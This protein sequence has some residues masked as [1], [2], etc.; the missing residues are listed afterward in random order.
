M[1]Q[2]HWVWLMAVA[3]CATLWP[4]AAVQA[5]STYR[6]NVQ[7]RQV[8]SDRPC[9]S[10][11]PNA[12]KTY[13]PTERETIAP[14]RSTQYG[15]VSRAP[16]HLQY[17]SPECAQMNDAIR[18]ASTR[19]VGHAVQRDLHTEYQRKCAD[20]DNEARRQV[21]Q[22]KSAQREARRDERTARA[23][24]KAQTQRER[25]Q[26]NE[27]LRILHAKRQRAATLTAGEQGDLQRFEENYNARCKL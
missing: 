27:M 22:D 8:L 7:G 10:S 9:A 1:I 20:D 16:D 21:Y 25:E 11:T 19:G 18:T 13:G 6:C 3:A 26:C 12:L 2:L 23:N 15:S 4:A 14:T 5:Q 17:L 24:E